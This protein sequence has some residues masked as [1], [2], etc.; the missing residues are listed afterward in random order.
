MEQR[1]ITE[2]DVRAMLHRARSF[3]PS[4]VAG[5]FMIDTAHS[6]RPWIVVVEPDDTEQLLV[7]V[8]AYEVAS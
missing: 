6:G 2:V 5:R 3:A 4:V 1:A 7:V 8:T